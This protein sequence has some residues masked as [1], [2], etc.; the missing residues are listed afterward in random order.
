MAATSLPRPHLLRPNDARPYRND[1][2]PVFLRSQRFPFP[3]LTN[4]GEERS[5]SAGLLVQDFI[6][7][8]TV[9]PHGRGTHETGR[10]L[11]HSGKSIYKVTRAFNPA[12]TDFGLLCRIPTASGY[13]VTGEMKHGVHTI[14]RGQRRRPRCGF[15]GRHGHSKSTAGV[16]IELSDSYAQFNNLHMNQD[17][18]IR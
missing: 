12:R 13:R 10:S 18:V 3:R 5:V 2:N 9:V 1:P 11:F 7:A 15:P 6:P 16:R 8:A 4:I 17:G 14:E